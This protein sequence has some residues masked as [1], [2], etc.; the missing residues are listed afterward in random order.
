MRTIIRRLTL[1]HLFLL[2]TITSFP[3]ASLAAVAVE[4]NVVSGTIIELN[5]DH[6]VKLD[7]GNTY[8]P[9]QENLVITLSVGEPVTLRYY[10]RGE[11]KFVYFEFAP[12]LNALS[13]SKA[14]SPKE[15]AELK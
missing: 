11:N 8:H 2:V 6:S 14:T 5:P 10:I 9:L 12:G 4:S 3:L 1:L 15:A 7:N 13:I